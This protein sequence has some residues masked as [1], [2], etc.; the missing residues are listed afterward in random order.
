MKYLSLIAAF[1]LVPLAAHAQD[2]GFVPLTSIP[3]LT[4]VGN[5]LNLEVFL[6]NLYRICI[7]VAA[8]LAVLQ[9]MRAGIMY[10][11]GDSVTE[12]KEA[13][14][15]IALAIGGLILV[16]SPV[17]VFSVI[18]PEILNL[19]IGGIDQLDSAAQGAA[20]CTPACTGGKVCDNGACVAAAASQGDGTCTASCAAGKVC[21]NRQCVAIQA[22][23]CP[24]IANGATVASAAEQTCCAAQSGCKVQVNFSNALASPTCSCSN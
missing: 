12:K 15:L 24:T 13:K 14:N 3:G 7:G 18:N 16:L 11:G 6:N 19:R 5:S 10:M 22:G 23:S 1:L 21:K 20:T 8:V 2:T 17:V 9:I 4:D